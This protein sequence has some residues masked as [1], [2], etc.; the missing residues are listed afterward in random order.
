M[1]SYLLS[2][3]WTFKGQEIEL[4][5][6]NVLSIQR[7]NRPLG[8]FLKGFYLFVVKHC[9]MFHNSNPEISNFLWKSVSFYNFPAQKL[10]KTTLF[11]LNFPLKLRSQPQA[12]IS[13]INSLKVLFTRSFIRENSQRHSFTCQE[14]SSFVFVVVF[15]SNIY[16]SLKCEF[17][18]QSASRHQ[19]KR[20]GLRDKSSKK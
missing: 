10:N 14:K 4:V 11:L 20:I 12:N 3:F 5:N 6:E 2:S 13:L 1:K 19:M 7:A 8:N 15:T 9:Q 18:R 17:Y 16:L